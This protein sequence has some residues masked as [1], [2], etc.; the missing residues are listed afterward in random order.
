MNRLCQGVMF[1]YILEG[2]GFVYGF[3]SL[4]D[5]I[6]TGVI[7]MLIQ[8]LTP[9]VIAKYNTLSEYYRGVLAFG[10]GASVIG[11]L[12]V[13][14]ILCPMKLGERFKDR[15]CSKCSSAQDG[16]IPVQGFSGHIWGFVFGP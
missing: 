9:D 8:K 14:I 16:A 11:A 1:T 13:T 3:M 15:T 7:I 10:C 6:S 4:I 2:S 5:K 12:I